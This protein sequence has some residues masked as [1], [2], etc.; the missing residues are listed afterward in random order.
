M[1]PLLLSLILPQEFSVALARIDGAK[2]TDVA[3]AQVPQPP[4]TTQAGGMATTATFGGR[5]V[6]LR[7]LGPADAPA[8]QLWLD[9]DADGTQQEREVVELAWENGAWAEIDLQPFGCNAQL[10]IFRNSVRT[11]ASL[12][13]RYHFDGTFAAN[14]TT[15]AVRCVDMDGDGAPS[16]GDRW[17]AMPKAQLDTLMQPN[18]MFV[19]R[20]TD[21]PW[22]FGERELRVVAVGPTA[23]TLRWQPL[24]MP[25]HEFLAARSARVAAWFAKDYDSQRDELYATYKLDQTRPRTQPVGWYHTLEFTDA[26]RFAKEQGKPLLVEFSRDGCG[27]CKLL[28]WATYPD[29]AVVARLQ[30]FA[31][32]RIDTELDLDGTA[33]SLGER[34]VPVLMLFDTEGKPLHKIGGFRPPQDLVPALDTA[35]QKAQLPPVRD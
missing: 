27:F 18:N 30:C 22:H 13:T 33:E 35:L 32:V 16:R 17:L 26:R 10:A 4:F 15:I 23:M 29:A 12:R 34:G 24:S 9:L 3:S 5:K 7:L 31:C 19:G 28:P 8:P 20:E 25:R 2:V 1:L 6:A 14:D 11:G 21:E